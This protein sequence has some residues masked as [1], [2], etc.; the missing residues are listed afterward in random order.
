MGIERPHAPSVTD[1]HGVA[2]A[3]ER[4]RPHDA[5]RAGRD[6]WRAGPGHEVDAGVKRVPSRSEAV[7]HRRGDRGAELERARRAADV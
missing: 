3:S 2:V 1:D 4:G 7:T 6:D 5:A